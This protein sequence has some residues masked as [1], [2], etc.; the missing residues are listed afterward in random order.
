MAAG[1]LTLDVPELT[2]NIPGLGSRTLFPNIPD[3]WRAHA[4]VSVPLWTSGRIESGKLEVILGDY[5]LPE[6]GLHVVMPPGRATTARVRALV[7]TYDLK[8]WRDDQGIATVT[9]NRPESL[10]SLGDELPRLFGEARGRLLEEAHEAADVVALREALALHQAA[11]LQHLVGKEKSVG[12]DQVDRW[13][14]GPLFEQRLQDASE[15]AL[16]HRDAAGD[17]D[18]D[19]DLLLSC[20]GQGFSSGS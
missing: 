4:G 7:R 14:V 15:R 18:T 9:L 11:L 1:S 19:Q 16:A 3:T 17:A 10:N 2:L 20:H 13:M 5:P 6:S 8:M 12:G